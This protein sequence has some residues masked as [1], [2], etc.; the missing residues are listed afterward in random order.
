MRARAAQRGSGG[1]GVHSA[2][3]SLPSGPS[4]SGQIQETGSILPLRLAVKG[5]SY[6]TQQSNVKVVRQHKIPVA[7]KCLFAPRHSVHLVLS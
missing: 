4:V 3:V 7:L 6:D 5:V 2:P 1:T